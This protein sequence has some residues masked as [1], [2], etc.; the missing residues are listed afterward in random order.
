MQLANIW[1]LCRGTIQ[2]LSSA[3]SLL[4]YSLD[5]KL[6]LPLSVDGPIIAHLHQL[7]REFTYIKFILYDLPIYG[8][9]LIL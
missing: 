8:H 5:N 3:P 2:L 6:L 4:T 7:R 9:L 1:Q